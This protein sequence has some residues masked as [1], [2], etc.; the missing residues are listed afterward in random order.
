MKLQHTLIAGAVISLIAG[1]AGNSSVKP[2]SS[3]ALK[4]TQGNTVSGTVTFTTQGEHVWM[5]AEVKNLT[6]G[7]HG[8]HIHEKGDC[9]APDATSAGGHFNPS[10]HAH[11]ASHAKGGHA[12]DMGNLTADANGNA[13]LKLEMDGITLGSGPNSIVGR[14]VIV[15]AK[16]DDLTSQPVGNAGAR[17]ACGVIVLN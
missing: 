8:F 10:T 3:A 2:G 1:C 13:Y 7:L 6:P 9:S 5:V 12:G 14:A 15:H 17:V 4:P 16:P 11:G